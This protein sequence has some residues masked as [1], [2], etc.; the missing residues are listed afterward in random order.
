MD[1]KCTPAPELPWMRWKPGERVVVRYRDEDGVRDALGYLTEVGIHSVTVDTKRG[2]V[3]VP[4]EKMIIGKR[5]PP[6]P[7]PPLPRT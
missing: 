7:M 4:A 6:P 3:K 5:V 1:A 2:L